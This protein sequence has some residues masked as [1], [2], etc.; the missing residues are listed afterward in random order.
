MGSTLAGQKARAI[1]FGI[2]CLVALG[3]LTGCGQGRLTNANVSK[4]QPKMSPA[5]VE[6]I[7]GKPSK[8]KK[9]PIPLLTTLRYH[10]ELGQ[11]E[12]VFN[13]IEGELVTKLGS[14]DQ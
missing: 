13:F 3:G 14:F 6:A 2:V 8:V 4:I 9:L 1:A 11:R 10:Y 7:L 12:V 5:E